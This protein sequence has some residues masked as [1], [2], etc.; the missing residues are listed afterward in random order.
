MSDERLRRVEQACAEL[1]A[2]GEDVTFDAVAARAN[3]GRATLYRRHELH[4]IVHEHR[5][6]AADALTLSG[7]AVQ[8]DQLRH[9]LEALAAKVRRHEEQLRKLTRPP[10]SQTR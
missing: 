3:I 5:Q 4:A 10:T 6:R 2:A 1:V 9:G 7:L 8:I